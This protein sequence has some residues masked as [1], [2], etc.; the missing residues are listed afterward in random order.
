MDLIG[1]KTVRDHFESAIKKIDCF[2]SSIY[3]RE[4]F[5]RI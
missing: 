3:I 4:G 2:Y 5:A 1:E